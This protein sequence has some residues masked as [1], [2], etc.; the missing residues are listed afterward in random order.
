MRFLG[1]YDHTID[2]KNRLFIPAKFREALGDKFYVCKG[3]FE[4]CL[5]VFSSDEFDKYISHFVEEGP[6]TDRKISQ[7]QRE[8]TA[9]STDA[10]LDKQGRLVISQKLYDKAKL[11][12]DIMI[13][14]AITR[15]EI[16]SKTVRQK[17]ALTPEKA[18]NYAKTMKNKGD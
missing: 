4:D 11:E 17:D 3:F 12:K 18:Y 5:Y 1:E 15:L 7:L 16:W 8:F 14:G 9:N 13:V 10:S 6:Y 2:D